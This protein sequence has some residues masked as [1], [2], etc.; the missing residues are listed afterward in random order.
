MTEKDWAT[1]WTTCANCGASYVA[2]EQHACCRS[3]HYVDGDKFT[4]GSGDASR[5]GLTVSAMSLVQTHQ[6]VLAAKLLR[7][8]LQPALDAARSV[9]NCQECGFGQHGEFEAIAA[10]DA[11]LAKIE[12]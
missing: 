3:I 7:S 9:T 11:I 8:A 5:H 6:L 2:G 4:F 12:K 1:N 10:F